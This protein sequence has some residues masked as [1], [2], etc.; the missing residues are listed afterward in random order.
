MS[1][2]PKST[3][4]THLTVLVCDIRENGMIWPLLRIEKRQDGFVK[5]E[6]G[7]QN[8]PQGLSVLKE[9]FELCLEQTAEIARQ[10]EGGQ[11]Y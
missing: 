3:L 6:S 10:N 2:Q 7:R 8:A 5:F 9:A 1:F 4:P 11:G